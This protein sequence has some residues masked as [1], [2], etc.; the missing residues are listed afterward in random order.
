MS[1][2]RLV[3]LLVSIGFS[4]AMAL[5]MS[6]SQETS[7][8][9]SELR[10]ENATVHTVGGACGATIQACIDAA[11]AGDR[12]VVPA[13]TYTESLLLNKAVSLTGVNSATTIIHHLQPERNETAKA[14]PIPPSNR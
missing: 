12:V 3:L 2:L 1:K 11:I 14:A 7:L 8:W 9:A 4:L 13:G 5:H 10:A 6:L